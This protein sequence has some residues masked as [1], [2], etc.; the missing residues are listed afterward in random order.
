MSRKKKQTRRQIGSLSAVATAARKYPKEKRLNLEGLYHAVLRRRGDPSK[1]L[2]LP[3]LS[4]K[5][6]L[7]VSLLHRKQIATGNTEASSDVVREVQCA[8]RHKQDIVF[9][10]VF[11]CVLFTRG[12]ANFT[13][14]VGSRV[15]A[16]HTTTCL[17]EPFI[18][19][20][21]VRTR[22]R[23]LVLSVPRLFTFL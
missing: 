19:I 16:F 21:T 2:L 6:P 12:S 17:D 10:F 13:V 20:K 23:L 11:F 1:C 15:T 14:R 5:R 7:Y 4:I 18:A 22:N 8:T 3:S 9:F